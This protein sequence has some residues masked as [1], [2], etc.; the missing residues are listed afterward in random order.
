MEMI[1]KYETY[2]GHP[3]YPMDSVMPSA[4]QS[5]AEILTLL[6]TL[7]AI[8]WGVRNILVKRDARLLVLMLAGLISVIMETHAMHLWRFFYPP[9]GQHVLYFALGQPV[10]VFLAFVY[11]LYFGLVA[12]FYLLLTG[13]GWSIRKFV[14]SIILITLVEAPM[15]MFF[16]HFGLWGYYADQPF[17]VLGFPLHVAFTSAC[18][19][20]LYGEIQRVWF[21]YV[22][23]WRQFAMLAL[24]PMTLIGVL[25]AYVYPVYFA[26]SLPSG[27]N[28]TEIGSLL[29]MGLSLFASYV[30]VKALSR[31]WTVQG[32]QSL[33]S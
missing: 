6:L 13:G 31:V 20:V 14:K 32:N 12:Y 4:G 5:G 21:H 25:T 24:G 19:C 23:G 2:F 16:I 33:R 9:K 11:S 18:M 26:F 29:S 7:A 1:Q 17:T 10:P 30:G 22:Q 3:D 8:G 15:E 28:A 27:S